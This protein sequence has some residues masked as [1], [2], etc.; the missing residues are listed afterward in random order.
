M[1]PLIRCMGFYVQR[2]KRSIATTCRRGSFFCCRVSVRR[3]KERQKWKF[4]LVLLQQCVTYFILPVTLPDSQYVR[5]H[6]S[7]EL[8]VKLLEAI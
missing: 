6:R 8:Q 1:V 3:L 2:S 7:V 4:L 5:M